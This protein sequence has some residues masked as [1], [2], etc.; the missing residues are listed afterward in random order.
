MGYSAEDAAFDCWRVVNA[1]MSQGV[2]RTT[3]GKG[4]DPKDLVMLAYGGNGPAFAAIQAEDL[5]I[6]RVLVPKASPTF[7]ALGTLVANPS[8]DEERSYIVPANQLDLEKL[9]GLWTELGRRAE[10]YFN[11]AR[12]PT[13][14]VVANYRFNMRYPGQNFALTF[15][16]GRRAA[17]RPRLH[18]RRHRRTRHRA[19]QRAGRGRIQPHP[20]GRGAR[21]H[22]R[23]ARQPRADRFGRRWRRAL[24]RRR[25]RRGRQRPGAR[26]WA[27]ALPKRRSIA[28]RTLSPGSVIPSP[29]IIEET[30]TTIV[31]YPGW[32]CR[33]DNSG[34]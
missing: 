3:A 11:D 5:G 7:S 26:T 25:R 17:S 30:F 1:N 33:I 13:E 21:D 18:R 27:R 16:Q 22:R 15:D 32:T 31:V 2:R 9:K 14:R 20:R 12:F 19:V 4:I 29:A 24:A 6:S 34:D 8:I 23:A 10:K 28:G